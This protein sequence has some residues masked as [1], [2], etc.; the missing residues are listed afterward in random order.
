VHGPVPV[1]E[2]INGG[3]APEVQAFLAEW[4]AG[5]DGSP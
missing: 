5:R 4:R 2:L 1:D 3:G